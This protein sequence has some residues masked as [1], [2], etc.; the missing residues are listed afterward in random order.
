MF[1]PKAS[2]C[3]SGASAN[4]QRSGVSRTR[5]RSRLS[6]LAMITT[7]KAEINRSEHEPHP[8]LDTDQALP[9]QDN[10]ASEPSHDDE[11]RQK[12]YQHRAQP[13]P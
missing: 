9:K 7:P 1:S 3:R 2:A 8:G 10:Q 13:L 5:R 4:F 6:A 11:A 12:E